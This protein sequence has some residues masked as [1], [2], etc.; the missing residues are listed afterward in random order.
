MDERQA[1]NQSLVDSFGINQ[2][3]IT[4]E[5]ISG[6][7]SGEMRRDAIIAVVVALFLM[8]IYIT[9]RFADFRFASAAIL[10]LVHDVLVLLTFYAVFRWSVGSTFVACMLT[11]VG[12]SI[13]DT[14]VVFDRIRENQRL[15]AGKTRE[16]IANKSV[17]ETFSRSILTSVTTFVAILILFVM[18]V[19]SIREFTL[20]LMVGT[21]CGTYS[22][23]ATSL[24][25]VMEKRADARKAEAKAAEKASEKS[26]KPQK[27]QKGQ[28]ASR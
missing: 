11:L 7:I 25:Y 3:K 22:S 2:E 6:T 20:P 26:A 5:N 21:V 27:S 18:G 12:Y 9:F 23:I 1:L 28:K 10:C 4:A 8:L 19:S 17:T 24:W 15:V 14:I 16:E 13:N